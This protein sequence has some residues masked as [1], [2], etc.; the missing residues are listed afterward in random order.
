MKKAFLFFI[1]V[2]YFSFAQDAETACKTLNKIN[3]LLQTEHY[4]PKA[5]NDSLSKALFSDFFNRI[6]SD[7]AFFTKKE[8]ESLKKHELK[9]DDYIIS[10][11]CEFLEEIFIFYKSG[12]ERNKKI[13]EQLQLENYA[14]DTSDTIYLSRG[15]RDFFKDEATLKKVLKKR[16]VFDIFQEI[17]KLSKNKDSLIAKINS[18]KTSAKEKVFANQFCK[19]NNLLNDSKLKEKFYADFYKTFCEYF[20]PHTNYFSNIEKNEFTTALNSNDNSLGIIIEINEDDEFFVQKIITGTSAYN[21]K[22]I[23]VGDQILNF[24]TNEEKIEINCG[25]TE[26]I[27]T[28]LNDSKAYNLKVTFRKKDGSIYTSTLE[29]NK[30]KNYQNTV[31]SLIVENESKYGYIKIPSFYYDELGTNPVSNDLFK[32]IFKLK[33]EKIKGLI[34]DLEFNGGGS[35]EECI[36]MVGMF[37][38]LGPVSV[39]SNKNEKPVILK[40]F[41]KGIV[42]NDPI[43]ILINGLSA[44]ASEFF[45]GTLKDYNRAI[46]LGNTTFGKGSMQSILPLNYQSDNQ[47]FIKVT[48]EKFYQITGKSNQS[49]GIQ[50]HIELPN[51]FNN[52]LPKEKDEKYALKNDTININLDF[53]KLN[54]DYTAVIQNSLNRINSNPYFTN[55]KNVNDKVD[56]FFKRK[57]KRV[58]LKFKNV[59]E[60]VHS[61]DNLYLETEKILK[62]NFNL[63]FSLNTFDKDV[64]Q[65]DEDLKI[66]FEN[67]IKE[68]STNAHIFEATNILNDLTK[69]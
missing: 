24:E 58:L 52:L 36:K 31:Y 4:K 41:N 61:L 62:T 25:T 22:K 55:I 56:S 14:S 29:K 17:S 43:V 60:D 57:E 5:V 26:K 15:K 12:I 13:I 64:I 46:L 23:S 54:T 34:I 19:I 8:I 48:I 59:F 18:L 63:K 28:I 9:I 42:Y 7:I 11:K 47:E 45:A 35:I 51:L 69:K 37:I 66:D 6:D 40:D 32:E 44:S 1:L 21:D 50:P 39:L 27:N 30:I 2:S 53:K 67:K 20:D 33:E 49:S 38:D 68:V 3:N 16:I 65:F 10:S